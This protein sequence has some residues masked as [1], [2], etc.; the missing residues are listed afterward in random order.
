MAPDVESARAKIAEKKANTTSGATRSGTQKVTE[1]QKER[2]H[3]EARR[4][5]SRRLPE[6]LASRL[7]MPRQPGKQAE[8]KPPI[9]QSSRVRR[10][11]PLPAGS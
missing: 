4:N 1:V 6:P 9:C 10:D 5:H 7:G 8:H 11:S 3:R 2:Q